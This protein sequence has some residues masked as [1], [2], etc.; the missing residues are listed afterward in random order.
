MYCLFSCESSTS[1]SQERNLIDLMMT[2]NNLETNILSEFIKT[3]NSYSLGKIIYR[4][5]KEYK[6]K[7]E[8]SSCHYVASG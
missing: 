3:A 7:T 5:G 1:I 4:R 2:L 6:S 8:E